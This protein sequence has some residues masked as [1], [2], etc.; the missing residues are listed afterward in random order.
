MPNK[1]NDPTGP[2]GVHTL[3]SGQRRLYSKILVTRIKSGGYSVT[4]TDGDKAWYLFVKDVVASIKAGKHIEPAG[5]NGPLC[6]FVKVSKG[7]IIRLCS[8]SSHR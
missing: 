3:N 2:R 4:M 5:N 1:L 8:C 6:I 7:R